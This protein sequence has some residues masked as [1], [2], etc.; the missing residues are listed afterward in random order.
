MS[1]FFLAVGVNSIWAKLTMHSSQTAPF[2]IPQKDSN[3]TLKKDQVH[4]NNKTK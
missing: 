2:T 3:A 4:T 1:Q